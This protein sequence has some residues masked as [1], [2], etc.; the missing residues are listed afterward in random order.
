MSSGISAVATAPSMGSGIGSAASFGS[1]VGVSGGSFS[2]GLKGVGIFS[3]TRPFVASIGS[4]PE[5]PIANPSSIFADSGWSTLGKVDIP[6]VSTVLKA[7][8]MR[9]LGFEPYVAKPMTIAEKSVSLKEG[10]WAVLAKAPAKTIAETVFPETK[11]LI[12]EN[13]M[14]SKMVGDKAIAV[15]V[16]GAYK[17]TP[18]EESVITKALVAEKEQSKKV[19]NLLAEVG[20]YTREEAA[21]RV[22]KIAQKKGLVEI[23][24]GVETE[25]ETEAEAEAMPLTETSVKKT[26]V[27]T[28]EVQVE[29]ED[30]DK[31]PEDKLLRQKPPKEVPVVD[32]KA[33]ASRKKEVAERIYRLFLKARKFGPGKVNSAEITRDLEKK[34]ENRSLLLRQLMYP[35]LPDGSLEEA[36]KTVASLGD[37]TDTSAF[38][39]QQIGKQVDEIFDKNVPVKLAK[40]KE[41]QVSEKDV[42]R[43]LKYLQPESL[44]A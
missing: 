44:L 31:K 4:I 8:P 36:S 16:E 32:D 17:Q 19:V 27:K 41:K 39:E 18:I 29:V 14:F 3:E 22:E 5:G 42:K 21:R 12:P 13:P 6:A 23:E 30:E 28:N 25:T 9:G 15:L 24:V 11:P 26:K 7:D 10:E 35:L 20:L 40:E 43:V 37:L 2:P 34:S 38:A 1:K 33:Q